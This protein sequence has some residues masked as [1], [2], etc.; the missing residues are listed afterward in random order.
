MLLFEHSYR[1][2]DEDDNQTVWG[3]KL[4]GML[5]FLFW[6]KN[7]HWP[8]P[9]CR[10]SRTSELGFWSSWLWHF[11]ISEVLMGQSSCMVNWWCGMGV[12]MG[13]FSEIVPWLTEQF[14]TLGFVTLRFYCTGIS[15]LGLK[16][17]CTHWKERERTCELLHGGVGGGGGEDSHCTSMKPW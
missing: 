2:S 9:R 8:H 14:V 12:V 6:G 16:M 7:I 11:H 15:T 5:I 13:V 17:M 1:D 3:S 4:V 10:Y